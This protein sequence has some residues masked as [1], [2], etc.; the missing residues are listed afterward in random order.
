[1]TLHPYRTSYPLYEVVTASGDGSKRR[2]L[3]KDL[4]R[5]SLDESARRAKPPF[6]HN[7]LREIEAYLLLEG[8]DLGTPQLVDH[9]DDWV[10]LEKIDGVE[11][12]QVGDLEIWR[13]VA[14]WLARFHAAF[15]DAIPRSNNLLRHDR[16]FYRTWADRARQAVGRELEGILASHDQIVARLCELP[17]VLIHGEF[18]CSNIMIAGRRIAPVDW[19]MAAIGPG[20]F[21]LA[22]LTSGG[23]SAP[24]RTTILSA[25]GEIDHEALDCCRL[26]LSLQWLGWSAGWSP[27]PEHDHDWLTEAL[28]AA[29]RL[30]VRT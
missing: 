23:W 7:P 4:R 6:L 18:Y 16:C 29:A 8:R 19:E 30:G 3:K 13:G 2:L 21:D 27:P 9:G 5:E 15:A 28:E 10:L 22:A 11:L 24:E 1:L 14:E 12:C 25:Y 20:L 17:G 26:Q